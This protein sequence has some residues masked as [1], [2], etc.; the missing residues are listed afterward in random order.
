M[1]C[2]YA[3]ILSEEYTVYGRDCGFRSQHSLTQA[4]S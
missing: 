2:L 3:L 4:D 1:T